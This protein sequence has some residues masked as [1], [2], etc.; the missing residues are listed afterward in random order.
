[1]DIREYVDQLF[2]KHSDSTEMK[3]FKEEICGNLQERIDYLIKKGATEEEAFN[4]ATRELGDISE[5]AD[6]ISNNKRK[7]V[8]GDIYMK[9]RSNYLDKWHLGGYILA[10]G[11]LAIGVI[12]TLSAYFTT[13]EPIVGAGSAMV[14]LIVPIVAFVF[15]GLTQETAKCYPMSWKRALCYCVSA[16]FIL[17]GLTLFVMTYFYGFAHESRH[18]V[19]GFENYDFP[20]N[21]V[22]SIGVLLPTVVPGA[23][24]LAFLLLTEKDRSKPWIIEMRAAWAE[25]INDQFGD[26]SIETKFGL[27]SGAL[28]IFAIALSVSL[29]FYIGFQYSWVVLLFAV[30][31]QLL[32]QAF[33]TPKKK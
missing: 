31:G 29:G 5:I 2:V 12:L 27:Y 33:M 4:K 18:F 20:V 24:L 6:Q 19:K 10:G 22:A 3:D 26:P 14:F 11:L 32:L 23:L 15:L 17:F 28:W 25:R 21:I 9:S 30:A 1:M 16:G 8:F 7:E 13:G